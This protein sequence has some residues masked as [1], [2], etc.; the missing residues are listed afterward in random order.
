MKRNVTGNSFPDRD[1]A[2]RM[3]SNE[4]FVGYASRLSN[5]NMSRVGTFQLIC[6]FL[7][8]NNDNVKM[9]KILTM[10]VCAL[11]LLS[12]KAQTIPNMYR[13]ADQAKM[14]HWVDSVFDS[15]TYDERVGQL[16]MVIA[17]PKSDN[18]NMQLLQRYVNDIKIGGIL[19]HKGNPVTQAEVT[20]RLQKLARVPMFISLDG[21][22]GLSMRLS[23]TTRFPKNMMLGAIEDN[24]LIVE[25]GKEVARQCK[26]LGIQINFA[27]DIDVNSNTDNPVIG[28]RSFGETPQAVADKGLAY[29]RGLEG[30]GIISVAKHFPGHG[31][32]SEDSH[33][34]LPAV[35]HSRA[36]LDS[37]ELYPFRRYIYDGYAGIMTGHLYIPALDKTRNLPSSLS[38]PIV[39][40]LLQ[41][42][43]GFRGLCFTD[44]LA[45][46]GATTNKSDNPSVKALLAGN[47]I[48]LA[49][50]APIND[51]AAVKAAIEE[52]ILNLK[53]IEAKCI[54][55]LQYKYIT[56]LNKYRPIDTK[57][58]SKRLNSPHAAWLAAKLNA[59]AI[60]LMKNENGTVPIKQ[61]DKKKIAALSIGAATGNEFQEMLCRYDSIACFSIGRNATAAQ[62]QNVYNK[63]EKYDVIICGIHTVRIPESQLLRQLAAKKELIYA[64]FTL[65]YF[66]KDYKNSIQK[67]KAVVMGYEGTPLAQEYAAQVIFGGVAAKGKLP[68]TI[69]G[70]YYAGTGLFTEKT[71]LGYH[72]P[73]EVGANA[74]RL[75][76]IESIVEEGLEQKAYP[77]C[78]VLVAKDGMVIYDKSFGYFDYN[79]KQKVD[80]NSVYDLASASKAAGTLLAV[81]KAYDEKKFTLT[82]K[83]SEFIPELKESNKKDLN[84]KEM[85]YHQSGV[86][87]TIN[88]YLSAIDK[89][90]Y[91][92]SLYSREKNATH[93]VR[94]DAKTF[95]RNDFKYLPDLVSDKK[96]PGFTTE[97]AR[98]FYIHDSFR[99]SIMLKIKDS[100]LGTRGKYVYSCVNFI[101]LKMMV[102]NQMKQPMDQLLNNDFYR[103]L[104]AYHTTY[105]PLRVMDTLQI[106]PTENDQFVRRQLLRGYVHDEAAA[107]Q[108]GVSGNAGLF[109]NANDLAKVLQLFLNQGSYGSEQYLSTETCRLFTQSKSPTSRRGLG[110]DKPAVGTNKSSPCSSLTPPSTYGHTGFTGT[111][112]WVDPDNQLIY[113]FLCNRV[114]PSR[115][116]SKLSRLDIRTRIQDAIYKAIK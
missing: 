30:A 76:V 14:N 49:P 41:E 94:F 26:E 53:D 13:N 77:G 80:G 111:C 96:K 90:S 29:A 75:D 106:V 82:N 70:L 16:F 12:A 39:T 32:T 88:F 52:G 85:L 56:G 61:L 91:K 40:G 63:L 8:D 66:C 28:L 71:R 2:K 105:N 36:R 31:D 18:R 72:E 11:C 95:V 68:V 4:S 23:G 73:E 64:F 24:Q 114:T 103:P 84:I 17:N 74:V 109:S 93:P 67:A 79:G 107:F 58:L 1:C 101:M 97:V 51:F 102:E 81:M 19:F 37:M 99:D 9:R 48:L 59:E 15:M 104:G 89:D 55:I 7:V 116:N 21:E 44:A 46:K 62:V 25:Y 22:W 20:N 3:Q 108:G 50:A 10:L 5:K 35:H 110:F 86:V 47:D 83:I 42:E 92:G 54:K 33:N 115:V 38:R 113:I 98:N 69:P 34:T 6:L 78:Q 65:P 112:F 87:S 100:R 60:T 27:P 57:G 45:M 43:L